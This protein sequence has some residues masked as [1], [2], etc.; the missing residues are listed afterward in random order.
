MAAWHDYKA[1]RD[2]A[3]HSV[4][5]RLLVR[6]QIY[7]PQLGNS[8]DILVYLPPSYYHSDRRY[9]VIYMH[10]GQ[11]LFDHATSFV[12]EWQVDE[13]LE[14]LAG[15]DIEAVAV[16]VPSISAERVHELSPFPKKGESRGLGEAYLRFIIETVKPMIDA[17]FRVSQERDRTGILGSSMGGLIS[18]YGFYTFPD[19][20]GF[21]GVLSPA[22]W[23]GN[24]AIYRVIDEQT[25]PLG[26]IYLDVGTNEA[27]NMVQNPVDAPGASRRYLESVRQVRDLL[28]RRGWKPDT[29]LK[30]VEDEGA[31]HREDAW[32][33]RLPDALRFLMT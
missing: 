15:E 5:G 31:V 19:I 2:S 18:L 33:R 8:R 27:G 24:R 13:T 22:L 26:R 16:G 23:F 7:S 11:N 4:T 25:P 6:S 20:F 14:R 29:T 9:P 10:D 28:V 32:A 17:S 3:A 12:G 21:T 1:G 30:Y